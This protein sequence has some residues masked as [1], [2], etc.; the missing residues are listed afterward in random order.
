MTELSIIS[1]PDFGK[2]R[3]L[4]VKGEPWFVAKDV[5]DILGIKNNRDSISKILDDDEK[6]VEKADTPGGVQE[7]GIVNESGLY[8]LIMRSN[9]PMA[10]VFRKWVTSEVLP[11]IRRNGFYVHPS[12]RLSR[13]EEKT[14]HRVMLAEVNRYIMDEDKR[15]CSRRTGKTMVYVDLVLEGRVDNNDVMRDLQERAMVN[16]QS[17]VDAYHPNRMMDVVKGLKK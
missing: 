4:T 7:I 8:S 12:A 13:K 16:R 14:L 6:G 1:H 5:C 11:S 2:V 3:N 9:K 10:K 17:W 15:R